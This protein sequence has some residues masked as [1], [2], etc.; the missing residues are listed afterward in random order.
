MLAPGSIA[1][2]ARP[3]LPVL[4]LSRPATLWLPGHIPH[5][6]PELETAGVQLWG[7]CHSH[8]ISF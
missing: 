5:T 1:S 8:S 3:S 6:R 2:A 4:E 7:V